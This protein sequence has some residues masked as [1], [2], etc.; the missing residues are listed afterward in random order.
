MYWMFTWL[1]R[2]MRPYDDWLDNRMEAVSKKPL[3]V[4]LWLMLF[5]GGVSSIFVLALNAVFPGWIY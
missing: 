3:K 4:R 1:G 2:A 5:L